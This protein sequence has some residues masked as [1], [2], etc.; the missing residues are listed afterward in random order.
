HYADVHSPPPSANIEL[1]SARPKA[2]GLPRT[3]L[4]HV[5]DR[6]KGGRLRLL[7]PASAW[8]M[9]T[10]YANDPKNREKVAEEGVVLHPADAA[11]LGLSEGA[12]AQLSNE[13]GEIV[14]PVHIAARTPRGV[15]LA[16]KGAWPKLGG[17]H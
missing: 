11:A 17:Q 8:A 10:S 16:V 6:P 2:M 13:E 15:A 5:D 7:S 3:P 12:L 1:A 9:N 14:M 4:P